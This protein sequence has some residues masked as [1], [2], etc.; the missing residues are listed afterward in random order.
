MEGKSFEVNVFV[1]KKSLLNFLLRRKSCEEKPSENIDGKSCSK[2]RIRTERPKEPLDSARG[3]VHL[4]SSRD[5]ERATDGRKEYYKFWNSKAREPCS[6][7]H[8][9]DYR[10]QELHAVIDTA[11]Q[12]RLCEMLTAKVEAELQNMPESK[13]GSRNKTVTK[14]IKGVKEAKQMANELNL[15][16]RQ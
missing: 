12:I 11:W 2:E 14:N 13:P 16:I 9:N 8:F 15:Q 7:P 5:I 6:D 3:R 10:K 4:Y 1:D